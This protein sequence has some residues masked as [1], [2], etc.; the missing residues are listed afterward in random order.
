M[1][2]AALISWETGHSAPAYTAAFLT[3]LGFTVTTFDQSS[4][5]T[6]N[7]FIGFD[8]I[9]L[10]R[11]NSATAANN[12]ALIVGLFGLGIPILSGLLDGGVASGD[13]IVWSISAAGFASAANYYSQVPDTWVGGDA[14]PFGIAGYVADYGAFM[15]NPIG[16]VVTQNQYGPSSTLVAKGTAVGGSVT[17]AKTLLSGALHITGPTLSSERVAL[18]T[19]MMVW[20][21]SDDEVST[22]PEPKTTLQLWPR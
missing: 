3:Q 20:L 18:A 12:G 2:T 16:T 8:V 6:P 9:C 22:T 17:T 19:E 4:L 13:G 14:L 21:I 7:S 11:L 10:I 5:S 1:R 15:T